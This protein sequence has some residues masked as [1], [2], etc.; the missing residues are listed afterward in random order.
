MMYSLHGLDEFLQGAKEPDNGM[1]TPLQATLS[2]VEKE[3][4]DFGSLFVHLL[5]ELPV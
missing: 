3:M 1:K 4:H 5:T 2:M